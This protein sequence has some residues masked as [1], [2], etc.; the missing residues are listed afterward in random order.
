MTSVSAVPVFV[1]KTGSNKMVQRKKQ[2]ILPMNN[3]IKKVT[4]INNYL[5]ID[6]CKS[7]RGKFLSFFYEI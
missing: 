7:L 2:E 6:S 4:H 5:M 1:K 3:P